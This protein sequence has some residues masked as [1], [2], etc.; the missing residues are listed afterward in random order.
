MNKSFHTTLVAVLIT[1]LLLGRA[2]SYL[3]AGRDKIIM[4]RKDVKKQIERPKPAVHEHIKPAV[5][6]RK[7]SYRRAKPLEYEQGLLPQLNLLRFCMRIFY[8]IR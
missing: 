1:G 4:P 5:Y 2:C 3:R 6:T 8:V 7:A